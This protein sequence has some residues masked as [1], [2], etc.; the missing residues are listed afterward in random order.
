[1]A[2]IAYKDLPVELKRLRQIVKDVPK[3]RRPIAET[4]FN[5]IAFMDKT[6]NSLKAQVNKEGPTAMFEQGSQKF[7]REHPA[8]K[9]YISLIQRYNQVM[10]QLIDLLPADGLDEDDPLLDFVKGGK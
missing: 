10:R 3:D 2:E 9:G 1:M 5:E 8:F 4:L 6:L 7:L